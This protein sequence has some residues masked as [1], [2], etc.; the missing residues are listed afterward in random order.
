MPT[1]TRSRLDGALEN[2]FITDSLRRATDTY[3]LT[4]PGTGAVI[5]TVASVGPDEARAAADLAVSSFHRWKAR[6]AFERAD[7]VRRWY[8]LMIE[9]KDQLGRLIASEMGKAVKEATG[10]AVYAANF[11]KFYAEEAIRIY[12]ESIPA[13][14]GHKRLQVIKQPVG[15][16]YAVT[17]WNF[18]AG[19]I[20]RKAAPALA[21]GCSVIVKPASQTPLTALRLAE[22]W[23]EAGGE[24]GTLQ[25]LPARSPRA[26]SEVLIGDRRIRK[27]TFT[28]ST[29]VGKILYR[30]AADTMKRI[31]L[32]LG[33]HAPLIVFDD[34]DL[35]LAAREAV[36][37]KFRNAGQTCVCTNRLIVQRGVLEEFTKR[38]AAAT[39]ALQVGDPLDAG[40]D[41]GPLVNQ[42]AVD[43]VRAH[44]QDAVD[45]GATVVTGGQSA[46]VAGGSGLF[47][48]PTVL[49]GVTED[50]LIMS[51]ETFGPVAPITVFDTEEE[52]IRIANDS[53]YG[54]ASYMFTRDIGRAIRVSEALEYGIVGI[55]DGIP[56]APHVPFGGVKDSGL[57]REGGRFGIEEYLDVKYVSIGF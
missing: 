15:P 46:Q 33:G 24:P 35:D 30:Q 27:L 39:K 26:I 20:T 36:A 25:V 43:K 57:G 22:L 51:E 21:A 8:D 38:F 5:A 4:S 1:H 45:R 7:I 34:A 50:M 13:M 52:A 31:S 2:T 44:I 6:T 14:H 37:C 3:E 17:P 56:S 29:E 10:E 42:N 28:G 55:N 53:D 16:V 41:I 49:S 48:E 32:E 9:H 54:L 11:A 12:G 47:F 19:M 18:P 23:L 40:T